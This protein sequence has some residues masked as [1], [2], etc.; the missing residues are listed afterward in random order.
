MVFMAQSTFKTS[1]YNA[2][3]FQSQN[4]VIIHTDF[5]NLST[6]IKSAVTLTLEPC[7]T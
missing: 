4:E 5:T 2:T 6:P 1:G 7:Q 3:I